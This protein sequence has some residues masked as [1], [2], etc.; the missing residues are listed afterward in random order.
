MSSKYF[1]MVKKLISLF[2]F[3]LISLMSF[4]VSAQE[5]DN[6]AN[7]FKINNLPS[8]GFAICNDPGGFMNVDCS[9]DFSHNDYSICSWQPS[10]PDWAPLTS[11]TFEVVDD[12][13]YDLLVLENEYASYYDVLL[14]DFYEQEFESLGIINVSNILFEKH[15]WLKDS[16]LVFFDNNESGFFI[17]FVVFHDRDFSYV[18]FFVDP[19]NKELKEVKVEKNIRFVENE[20]IKRAILRDREI[21]PLDGFVFEKVIPYSSINRAFLLYR[22]E[23]DIQQKRVVKSSFNVSKGDLNLTDSVNLSKTFE[24]V[25]YSFVFRDEILSY[26]DELVPVEDESLIDVIKA[27]KDERLGNH[28][29]VSVV[30]EQGFVSDNYKS[31]LESKVSGFDDVKLSFN[32]EKNNVLFSADEF[33]YYPNVFV[34]N[35]YVVIINNLSVFDSEELA[36]SMINTKDFYRRAVF[37]S[38]FDDS[39]PVFQEINEEVFETYLV[40]YDFLINPTNVLNHGHYWIVLEDD[41]LVLSKDYD[42]FV[43]ETSD[44]H[45]GFF[46]EDLQVEVSMNPSNPLVDDDALPRDV[47]GGGRIPSGSRVDL[48]LWFSSNKVPGVISDYSG[49]S[50]CE[51]IGWD[52]IDLSSLNVFLRS[53]SGSSSEF[54]EKIEIPRGSLSFNEA[55]CSLSVQLPVKGVKV[56]AW[57]VRSDAL[58]E[59]FFEVLI[60][61][62]DSVYLILGS[63]EL[64][65]HNVQGSIPADINIFVP[66]ESL[67]GKVLYELP[68]LFK[69]SNI[70]SNYFRYGSFSFSDIRN[71]RSCF[72]PDGID[73]CRLAGGDWYSVD[74]FNY[75][76]SLGIRGLRKLSVEVSDFD[77]VFIDNGLGC[78]RSSASEDKCGSSNQQMCAFG[79]D[80]GLSPCGVHGICQDKCLKDRDYSNW[81]PIPGDEHARWSV[82]GKP[83]GEADASSVEGKSADKLSES[84]S[85]ILNI[86]DIRL[87]PCD[88]NNPSWNIRGVCDPKILSK[89]DLQNKHNVYVKVSGV[90]CDRYGLWISW[91]SKKDSSFGSILDWSKSGSCSDNVLIFSSNDVSFVNRL[92]EGEYGL[93]VGVWTEWESKSEKYRNWWQGSG[94]II[95]E[96]ASSGS[97]ADDSS[98]QPGS[99]GTGSSTSSGTGSSGSFD[100]DNCPDNTF[101]LKN[102]NNGKDYCW[103]FSFNNNHRQMSWAEAIGHCRNNLK[104]FFPAA[105]L[106][107][108]AYKSTKGTDKELSYNHNVLGNDGIYN[109]GLDTISS[110]SGS[111]LLMPEHFACLLEPGKHLVQV[112]PFSACDPGTIDLSVPV[113]PRLAGES[114]KYVV[115]CFD[116]DLS[117]K[118]TYDSAIDYCRS[119]GDGWMVAGTDAFNALLSNDVKKSS[120]WRGS[121][122]FC[123]DLESLGFVNCQRGKDLSNFYW[124]ITSHVRF[125]IRLYNLDYKTWVDV[126]TGL[127]SGELS[128]EYASRQQYVLC[129]KDTGVTFG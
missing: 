125:F 53:K 60:K 80:M 127:P 85:K 84:A 36:M 59:L 28:V 63:D 88:S 42:S 23:D 40:V 4:G 78:F 15:K 76:S 54:P 2:I 72:L 70:Q 118:M 27:L 113:F 3:L 49:L 38:F 37:D 83:I 103:W 39:G 13:E 114:Q 115:Y 32:G 71:K 52:N 10:C 79:C 101:L 124:S 87:T 120:F 110:V 44:V 62:D 122:G 34:Y 57:N 1:V 9:C 41:K 97:S 126:R 22:H 74:S 12:K 86:D 89:E 108:Y 93:Q 75:L 96:G 29:S 119:K 11:K 30:F 81:K 91:V 102:P 56:G 109:P 26:V 121:S 98:S 64:R 16:R 31:L 20:V 17:Y 106:I 116:S 18:S 123:D 67:E 46:S 73:N 90:N 25:D 47:G 69:G 8:C 55:T 82:D 21:N 48:L 24:I 61:V 33:S 58:Y 68:D 99:S 95:V 45:I 104:G 14:K 35:N 77:Q 107:V 94:T 92:D 6:Q 100:S 65:F 7:C 19:F 105:D 117:Q 50:L 51:R 112:D 43:E 5:L 129:F 128:E 111:Y 66:S